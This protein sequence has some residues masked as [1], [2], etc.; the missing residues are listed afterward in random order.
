MTMCR[1][2]WLQ[3][4]GLG[5]EIGLQPCGECVDCTP[6]AQ[7]PAGETSTEDAGAGAREAPQ[8]DEAERRPTRPR[9][10]SST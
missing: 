3:R 1:Y 9:G 6:V 5:T 10:R 7:D 2:R 4:E 8:G